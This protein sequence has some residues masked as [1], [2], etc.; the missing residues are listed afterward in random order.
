MMVSRRDALVCYVVVIAAVL[1]VSLSVGQALAEGDRC[2]SDAECA[3]FELCTVSL[4]D[5]HS[6]GGDGEVCTG[7][8]VRGETWQLVPRVGAV[9]AGRSWSD[10][11]GGGGGGLDV[12]P[13]VLGGVLSVVADGWSQGL[14]RLG[15]AASFPVLPGL[16]TG[17][18]VDA[19]RADGA[20]GAAGA[21]R[22]EWFP[23]WPFDGWTPSHV[24]SL[25]VEGGAATRA[26]APSAF[27][28]FGLGLWWPRF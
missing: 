12:I 20:W 23:W 14:V 26:D 24:L 10:V 9:A 1:I 21:V 6:S 3:P 17:V 25:L 11:G 27:A 22:L 8:C 5:C 28:T 16:L 13:P 2:Q 18:R 7:V 15:V 4:G 19:A